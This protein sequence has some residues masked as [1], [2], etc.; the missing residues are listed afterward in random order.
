MVG[1]TEAPGYVIQN[2]SKDA[3]YSSFP[4]YLWSRFAT[5]LQLLELHFNAKE[6]LLPYSTAFSIFRECVTDISN[7]KCIK[8]SSSFPS[9]LSDHISDHG[10]LITPIAIAKNVVLF[11][12]SL[13][14]L[15]PH[16]YSMRKL[17]LHPPS[18]LYDP[19]KM[20]FLA[21]SCI[22]NYLNSVSKQASQL[23]YSY[24]TYTYYSYACTYLVYTY[25]Y[26]YICMNISANS[27]S[28]SAPRHRSKHDLITESQVA[29]T[30][31]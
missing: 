31:G 29:S 3:F 19:V 21:L 28:T 20:T 17:N 14:F 25:I 18:K 1:Q 4:K 11:F 30:I 2:I 10:N 24:Y 15:I 7:S 22:I 5:T 16:T 9:N 6:L 13:C 8:L 12:G 23:L 27:F 26:I